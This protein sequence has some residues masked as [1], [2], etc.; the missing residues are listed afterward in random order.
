[1]S[2]TVTTIPDGVM[3]PIS[4]LPVALGYTGSNLT[5][6]TVVYEGNTY[7][8]TISYSGSQATALSGWVLT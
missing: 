1:M 2:E 3:L 6:L 7:V 8:N 4:S 5:T